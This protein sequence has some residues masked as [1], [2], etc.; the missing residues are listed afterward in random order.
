MSS[1]R[2]ADE[3]ASGAVPHHAFLDCPTGLVEYY[4][5][6]GRFR[7]SDGL[8]RIYG[9][10]RG[11]VVPSMDMALAHIENHD[12]D[13]VQAYWDRV[14]T[15]GGPLSMYVSIRDRR[16]RHRKLLF[17]ADYIHDGT[18]PVGVW[19]VVA[20]ITQ[21]INTDR[22]QLATEAVAAS[23]LNRAYIEQAKGILMGRAGVSADRAYELISQMSRDRNR[24]V[25]QIA[26]DIIHQATGED[27]GPAS[28]T[29]PA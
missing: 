4:F 14:S 20:D 23:A 5:A 6:E 1:N 27:S 22:Q 2:S 28:Q 7:W 8:Y 13:A 11:D 17:S 16:N 19:G 29:P 12:R 15:S 25:H 24:K 18:T 26:Q 21:P 3:N 9:Y 10:E